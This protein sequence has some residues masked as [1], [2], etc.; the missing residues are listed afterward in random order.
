VKP[1]VSV[2]AEIAHDDEVK[3]PP[4]DE[5]RRHEVPAKFEPEAVTSVPIGPEVGVNVIVRAAEAV[6]DAVPASPV[7]PVTVTEYAP[8]AL[9]AT[10]N[11]PLIE[12]A[13]TV[14]TGFKMRVGEDG[15]DEI[16]QLESLGEKFDP[17]TRTVVPAPPEVGVN[18]IAAVTAK[19][20]LPA[21]PLPPLF[22]VRVTT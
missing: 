17:E 13:A 8:L 5:D 15:D 16:V 20:A 1:P 6:N 4:G 22:P 21:S 11:D 10:V 18:V 14:Q 2:P 12:P 9:D 3:R 7:V 19:L